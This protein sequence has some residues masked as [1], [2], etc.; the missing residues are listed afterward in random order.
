[1]S[2]STLLI[3]NPFLPIQHLKLKSWYIKVYLFFKRI[4]LSVA[5]MINTKLIIYDCKDIYKILY[6]LNDFLKFD[7]VK[8]DNEA[9][10]KSYIK[11]SNT[12]LIISK[13]K[14]FNEKN[15]LIL[16]KLPIKINNLISKINVYFLKNN[17]NSKSNISIGKYL[18]ND[19]SRK[20]Y[21][22]KKEASLTEQEVKLLLYLKEC[23]IP[24]K[25]EK[26]QKVIWGY[27]IDLETHTVETH[28][29]R[30][31]KKFIKIFNDN[32]FILTSKNGYILSKD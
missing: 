14:I 28:I 19:N 30:L 29:Y 16:D 8:I 26:L 10:L 18:L 15:E 20:I 7:L 6:E 2:P 23:K 4:K 5:A 25:V 12:F 21:F 24:T 9:D 31:R 32:D 22:D 3:V 17:F 27:N 11:S 13:K 1:M